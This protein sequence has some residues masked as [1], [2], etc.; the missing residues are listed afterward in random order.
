MIFETTAGVALETET[1]GEDQAD[2]P[3]LLVSG[4]GSPMQFW[5]DDICH[6]LGAEG[7]K[8]VRYCHRDTGLSDHF[9]RPYS[10]D[11][12]LEDLVSVIDG[13]AGG[14]AHLAGH[15]MGGYLSLLAAAR[16][17]AKVASVAAISCGPTTDPDRYDQFAMSAV[18]PETWA[19]LMRNEPSGDFDKDLPGWMASWEF[20][21]GERA[22]D[23]KMARGYTRSLY[24]GDAR[25]AQV[26]DN[27]IHAMT[28]LPGNFPETLA[29]LEMPVTIF[30]GTDDPLVPFDNGRALS[31]VVPGARLDPL[32]GAGHMFFDPAVWHEMKCAISHSLMDL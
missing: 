30:H 27:H 2:S 6:A 19:V 18:S 13:L 14:R 3:L 20:L 24:R 22:F 28:T 29:A 31:R 16:M 9:D 8:V 25:N 7:R 12:L 1:F 11:P 32:E 4:A 23:H 17:P 21:N 5:P 10:V 26:A 15:S